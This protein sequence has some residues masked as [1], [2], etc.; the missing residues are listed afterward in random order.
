MFVVMKKVV[1][2]AALTVLS[3]GCLEKTKNTAAENPAKQQSANKQWLW[4]DQRKVWNYN[5]SFFSRKPV[6]PPPSVWKNQEKAIVLKVESP[7]TLTTFDNAP[8][9]LQM[10][11]FQLSDATAFLQAAQTASGLKNLLVTEP[12]D[13]AIMAM[14]RLMILPGVAQTVTLDRKAGVRY[15]GIVLGYASLEQAKIFRLIPLVSVPNENER[16]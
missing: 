4:D 14:Q 8:N 12:I 5:G 15:V 1:L 11:V 7:N 3:A 13:P 9:A 6:E 2:L 16:Q 10:K